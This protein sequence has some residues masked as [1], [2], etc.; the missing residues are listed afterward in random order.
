MTLKE[1]IAMTT[2]NVINQLSGVAQAEQAKSKVPKVITEGMPELARRAAADGAVLLKND[3]VLP[4]QAGTKVSLFSRV[5]RDWFYV[6][7]GSGGDVNRP[8]AVSLTEGIRNCD[9]LELNEELAEIYQNWSAEHPINHGVWGRWPLFYPDMPLTDKVASRAAI[10]SDVAVV[11]IGRSAGEDRDSELEKGSYYLTDEELRLLF[12]VTKYFQKTVVLL[13]TGG[14]IDMAWTEQFGDRISAIMYVWQGGME[15][16]KAIA[17]LLSGKVSP[18]GRLADTIVREYVNYPSSDFFGDKD[19]N[20]YYEDIFVGYRYFETFAPEHVLYPFGFGLSY[21]DFDVTYLKTEPSEGGFTV[22]V[23]VKNTGKYDSREVVQLYLE[24]P[25]GKLGNPLRELVAFAKTTVLAPGKKQEL[26]L[27]VEYSQLASY[28]D[29]G[30]TEYPFADVVE[31]GEYQLYL[32]TNVRDAVPVY[33]YYQEADEVIGQHRQAAAPQ[34]PFELICAREEGGKRVMKIK[35]AQPMKY[36]LGARILNHLPPDIPMTGDKGIKLIDVKEGRAT[37]EDFVAQLTLDELEAITRGDYN[38]DS[39]LGAAGNAGAIG[40]VLPSLR[41]KGIPPMTTTDGPSGIRL[42]ASCSLLPNG[43]LLACTFDTALL[44]ELYGLIAVEMQDRGSDIL[45]GPGI[46]IHR[47]PLCGRNF[48]Y[49]SEDPYLTGKMAAAAVRGI[50][51]KGASACPKHYACNSQEYKRT[52]C[53]SRLSERALRQIY[54]KGFEMCV[55]EAAPKFIMTSYNKING[56]WGHYHYD[57]CTTVLREEWQYQGCVMTDW[58]MRPSKSPEFPELRDQA[59]RVRAQIDVLMPGADR[60]N[61]GKPDGTLLA[62]YGKP[63][64]IR[65]GEMQRC[66]MN[67]LRA[68]MNIKM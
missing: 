11:T 49:Y 38:M 4:L 40:G 19:Y 27:F 43:T 51:S 6:G 67:V 18:S 42:K 59:Y 55:K 66:A 14:I 2:T 1:R 33:A 63:L 23:S 68:A 60:I 57:L 35:N 45:L 8:Y 26:T 50:Q 48:E 36:D 13:N 61:N 12:T 52:V 15:S 62:S 56:I 44:E 41:D 32:G 25:N 9:A 17:D 47:N 30:A 58:W 53:D 65:L 5:A 39:K 21:T 37:P 7:Y 24:K 29:C 3:G 20:E 28:D 34:Q 31:A 46:N 22:T 10:V 64:G 54:L 16:G